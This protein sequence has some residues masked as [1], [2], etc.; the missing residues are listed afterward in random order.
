MQNGV[1][2]HLVSSGEAGQYTR[3]DCHKSVSWP[4]KRRA[5]IQAAAAMHRLLRFRRDD[6]H[7]QGAG[8][9]RYP[10]QVQSQGGRSIVYALADY[11]SF[12]ARTVDGGWKMQDEDQ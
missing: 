5:S 8:R 9:P 12:L 2:H 1:N 6:I 10:A 11:D 4:I 3:F 7:L